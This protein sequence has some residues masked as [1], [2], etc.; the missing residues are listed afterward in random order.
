MLVVT[1]NWSITDG[2]LVDPPGRSQ[3]AKFLADIR[4]SAA[5]AGIRRD[6]GYRPVDR[7][8]VVLAGDTFDWLLTA[9]WLGHERPWQ[10]RAR[11]GA[12]RDRVMHAT[13]K[14]GMR[15]LGRL[16]RLTREGLS[17]PGADGRG[18]PL[19]GSHVKVPV[20]VVMLTGD[21]DAGLEEP[22]SVE[23]AERFGIA[24]GRSWNDAPVAIAHGHATDPLCGS[25]LCDAI[26]RP[27]TLHESL[28]VDLFA[29]FAS[30]LHDME[31][32]TL[33]RRVMA[34]LVADCPLD[35]SV[36]LQAWLDRAGDIGTLS[37]ESR[38]RVEAAW[39]RAIDAWHRRARRDVP[40][41]DFQ[42]DAVDALATWLRRSP[43]AMDAAGPCVV[44][45]A[46]IA[47]R[48][49]PP[50]ASI[51]VFGHRVAGSATG[52]PAAGARTICLG[53]AAVRRSLSSDRFGGDVAT[54]A[55][56]IDAFDVRPKAVTIFAPGEAGCADW[57][58]WFT[59]GSENSDVRPA[60]VRAP[61]I[62]D[63]A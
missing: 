55:P 26:D 62:V 3:C 39:R 32:A 45:A 8:D 27:P 33:A 46:G 30:M 2:T 22:R 18:R 44:A 35:A 11:R 38:D 13:L 50:E 7:V 61:W 12:A 15:L 52:G 56:E 25:A 57:S 63:A 43:E 31:P 41:T 53:P 14:R 40:T 49:S 23:W 20:R 17:V 34:V 1:A 42:F 4:R 54:I 21:R 29:R 51:V 9:A 24:V 59:S 16:G 47:H 36:R 28:S 60:P 37:Q 6:G 5:R 58:A 19:L 10:P 48:E